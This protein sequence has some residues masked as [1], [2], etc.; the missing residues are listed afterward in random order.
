MQ[1]YIDYA[2]FIYN[3]FISQMYELFESQPFILV[4]SEVNTY[5][6]TYAQEMKFSHKL[7]EIG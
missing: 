5:Y 1:V 7:T 6:S 2:N 4:F 3:I